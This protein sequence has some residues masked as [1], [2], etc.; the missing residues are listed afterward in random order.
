MDG[1]RNYYAG[2][3][4]ENSVAR[5]YAD[6]GGEITDRRWRCPYGEI[7]LI[8]RDGDK[9]IFIEVKSSRTH[10]RAAELLRPAQVRRLINAATVY[11]GAAFT[12]MFSEVRFDLALVDSYGRVEI[13]E[14]AITA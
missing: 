13:I 4:A 2:V 12:Q 8:A 3:M 6:Q 10:A 7:D 9:L 1:S 11:L 14:N 5:H